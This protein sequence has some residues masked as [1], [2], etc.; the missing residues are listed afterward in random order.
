MIWLMPALVLRSSGGNKVRLDTGSRIMLYP[1]RTPMDLELPQACTPRCVAH[2]PCPYLL[3]RAEKAGTDRLSRYLAKV[4]LHL[5]TLRC[6]K[7][8]SQVNCPC[9]GAIATS[10]QC[11]RRLGHVAWRQVPRFAREDSG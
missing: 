3:A 8:D 2:T 6:D 10:K 5:P 9:P 1:G 11:T 7:N 4:P